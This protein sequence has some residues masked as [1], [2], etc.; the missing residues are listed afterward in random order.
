MAFPDWNQRF[1][2]ETDASKIGFGATL[3][4]GKRVISYASRSIEAAA[5]IWSVG[6]FR[7]YLECRPFTLIT[8]H[9]S[10]K[11]FKRL[12]DSNPTL[13]RWSGKD[14]VVPD[15]LSRSPVDLINGIELD[16]FVKDQTTEFEK[17]IEK[18]TEKLLS[19]LKIKDGGIDYI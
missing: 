7:V 5:I 18:T 14:H 17:T 9:G 15:C 12:S 19:F 3:T 16:E 2:L 13:E 8:D 4:Q 10:L 6:K 11:A 1:T